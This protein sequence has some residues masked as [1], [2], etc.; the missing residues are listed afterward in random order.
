[1]VNTNRLLQWHDKA[2]EPAGEARSDLYI[3][4]QLGLRFK[5]LY[6]GSDRSERSRPCSSSRGITPATIAHER[7]DPG[8]VGAQGAA[9]RSAATR[10]CRSNRPKTVCQV[11]GFA[12]LKSRRHD[13][14]RLLDLLRR[15]AGQDRPIAR[16]A[17]RATTWRRSSGVS[18]GR[19]TGACSTT[20]HPR[21]PTA[22]LGA[23]ARSTSS[24]TRRQASGPGPTCPTSRRQVSARGCEARR[25]RARRALRKRSVH[26]AD[27]R[28]RALF[29]PGG[30][31]RRPTADALRAA[32]SRSFKTAVYGQQSNPTLREWDRNDN[33][34]NTPASP[35]FPYMLTTYRITEHSGIM[36]R[37]VPWLSELQPALFA[38]IDPELAVES[39][40][41]NGDWVTISTSSARSKR[42]RSSADGC[43]RSFGKGATCIRSAFRITS[44]RSV[45]QR[46]I[47]SANSCRSRWTPTSRFTKPRRSRARFA[48]AA[49]RRMSADEVRTTCRPTNGR[50][51]ASRVRT[52]A[53]A[54]VPE[55]NAKRIPWRTASLRIRRFASAVRP[56]RSR[57]SSG[58]SY[59]PTATS[60]PVTP[61]TTRSPSAAPPGAT[62]RSSNNG[63]AR[64]GRRPRTSGS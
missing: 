39:F 10:S 49:V 15:H 3:I 2:V 52:A 13:G 34:Y 17:A 1:M 57:A 30:A 25:R 26:H 18:R 63:A 14:L 22:S 44:V 42:G 35:D 50:A 59:R 23:N 11:A 29:V 27:R 20:A 54:G 41:R 31:Q 36:T 47:P 7:I 12:D 62:S 45:T 58:T 60:S 38:E 40:L 48:R 64:A 28:S 51:V 5:K 24:G 32:W 33:P 55:A 9:T 37:Y 53:T 43:G 56:A 8:A 16:A 4:H 61:T 19:R 21:I 46:A 6:A